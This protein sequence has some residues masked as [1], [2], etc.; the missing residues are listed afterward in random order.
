MRNRVRLALLWMMSVA[1]TAVAGQP[2]LTIR[3][4]DYAGLPEYALKETAARAD[5]IFGKAGLEAEWRLCYV[6][7]NRGACELPRNNEGFIIRVISSRGPAPIFGAA[8]KPGDSGVA[9]VYATIYYGRVKDAAPRFGAPPSL[10]L[11]CVIAHEAGELLGLTHAHEGI[12]HAAFDR[13]D[14]DRAAV[15]RLVFSESQERE[16]QFSVLDRGSRFAA[17]PGKS[18]VLK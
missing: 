8:V 13:S 1:G 2:Q 11:A 15:G 12:M 3:L 4:F 7:A 18:A 5:E 14:L 16:L 17:I 10:L 6:P 9:G